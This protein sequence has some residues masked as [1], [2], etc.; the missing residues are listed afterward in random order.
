MAPARIVPISTIRISCFHCTAAVV[1]RTVLLV[2]ACPG[3]LFRPL[4]KM[5]SNFTTKLLELK[6]IHLDQHARVALPSH[7]T[8]SRPHL[9]R[10]DQAPTLDWLGQSKVIFNHQ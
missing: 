4:L 8:R 6:R 1:E 9:K 7:L 2:P 10:N 3:F 5:F